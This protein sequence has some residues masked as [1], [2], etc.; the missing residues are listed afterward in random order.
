M[1]FGKIGGSNTVPA[2]PLVQEIFEH[3]TN[4]DPRC[5]VATALFQIDPNQTGALAFLMEGVTNH[6]PA[7]ERYIAAWQLGEIGPAASAAVPVLLRALESTNDM[8]FSMTLRALK[9]IGVAS[10]TFLPIVKR[11]LNSTNDT[12]RA[13]VAARILETAPGDL[14]AQAV[15]M[16][17]IQQRSFFEGFAIETL[18]NAGASASGALPVL[19]EVTT[20]D[21]GRNG[22]VARRAIKQI[23]SK[24]QEKN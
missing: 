16:K 22:V 6:Q 18:E 4:W 1:A 23:E 17:L 24:P 8:L 19:R 3:E 5:C 12:V 21:S 10:E 15:L 20:N 14:E 11:R 2:I 13:N 9:N 7:S